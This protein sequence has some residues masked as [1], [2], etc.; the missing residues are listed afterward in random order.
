[1]GKT[2]VFQ[3]PILNV[4]K[5]GSMETDEI[6]KKVREQYPHLCVDDICDHR[7]RIYGIEWKH[8]LRNARQH[9]KDIERLVSYDK[10]TR[11]W[12]LTKK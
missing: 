7:G 4:L 2:N 9:L 10:S 12:S 3:K 1:M 5:N 6:Y 8:S 11:K